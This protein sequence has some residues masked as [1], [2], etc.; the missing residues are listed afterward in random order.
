MMKYNPSSYS[1]EM[2]PEGKYAY[3]ATCVKQCPDHLLKDNGACVRSCPPNKKNN[4]RGECVPC[5]GPCPKNCQGVDVVHASNIDSFKECTI[6]E[7]SLTILDTSFEGYQE[8][9]NNFT[10]GPRHPPMHPDKLEVF[11]TLKQVTGYVSIQ[12]THRDFTNLSYFRNLEEIGGRQLTEYFGALY[13]IKTTLVSLNLRSL[14]SVRSGS[15][16]ILENSDLCFANTVDWSKVRKSSSSTH[17]TLLKKNA[18]ERKCR[19][20]SQSRLIIFLG[21]SFCRHIFYP[22]SHPSRFACLAMRMGMHPHSC[23]NCLSLFNVTLCVILPLFFIC[24]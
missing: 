11:S 24:G 19:K 4:N 14:K 13:I 10:F 22:V 15:V 20:S 21:S 16:V 23:K 8:V 12:A 3:G 9:Y 5:D 17:S 7:G 2:N 1:W 6:I 18:D